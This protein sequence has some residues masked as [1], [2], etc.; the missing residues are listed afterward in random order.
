MGHFVD[1][2]RGT[3]VPTDSRGNVPQIRLRLEAR[4]FIPSVELIEK[5]I[6]EGAEALRQMA[7][8]QGVRTATAGN[9][10]VFAL[11]MVSAMWFDESGNFVRPDQ[12]DD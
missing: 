2:V 3:F 5:A 8:T 4:D 11:P 12:P 9:G 1:E 10:E 6:Q 7:R